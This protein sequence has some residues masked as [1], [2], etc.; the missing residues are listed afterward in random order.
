[1]TYVITLSGPEA[2][3]L[4]ARLAL[5]A[6]GFTPAEPADIDAPAGHVLVAVTGDDINLA[7]DSVRSAGYA[8]RM[9]AKPYPLIHAYPISH[10]EMYARRAGFQEN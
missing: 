2:G 3:E 1:M 8:L 9:H 10:A 4:E 5:S 7:A 6:A